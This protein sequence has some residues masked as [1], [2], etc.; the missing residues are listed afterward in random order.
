[1]ASESKKRA[2]SP[3]SLVSTDTTS[4]TITDTESVYSTE[5]P[6]EYVNNSWKYVSS[7]GLRGEH[8][9]EEKLK[10]ILERLDSNDIQEICQTDKLLGDK[11]N[12]LR[13]KIRDLLKAWNL[14]K[15]GGKKSRTRRVA[16]KKR[17]SSRKNKNNKK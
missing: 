5:T 6:A 13:N 3:S 11:C 2:R 12:A 16:T 7:M 4:S 9:D 15:V 8:I 1:M 14:P 17:R 10:Q